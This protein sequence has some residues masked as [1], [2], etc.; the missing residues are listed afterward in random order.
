M[1][2]NENGDSFSTYYIPPKSLK[3]PVF[4]FHHGAG[5]SAMTF[6]FLAKQ[7]I[8]LMSDD[9]DKESFEATPGIFAYDAR[10]H[11][12]TRVHDPTNFSIEAFVDDAVFIINELIKNECLEN[13]SLFLIGH[14]FGGSVLTRATYKL[15][16]KNIK[17]LGMFD[18]VE[19]TAVHALQGMPVYLDNLPRDFPS[20]QKA[21]D[22]HIHSHLLRNKDSAELSVPSNLRKN[23]QTGKYE[24]ITDLRK[25]APYWEKWFTDLSKSFV[26]AP[27]SKLLILAGTDSL[28]KDL[29]VG[30]M[31]GKYQLVVFQD[32]GHFIQEDTPRKTALTLIDFWKRNDKSQFVIKSTWGS[33]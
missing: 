33:K 9:K 26:H 28:D 12:D 17:G 1:V 19:Q 29:L 24:W 13:H 6:G 30:Q 27:T 8:Q 16:T 32:S 15:N 2:R 3:S 5:S 7:L 21:I 25:T 22:Y 14:S 10:G 23:E 4:I 20:I 11:G 31:Q 18:I